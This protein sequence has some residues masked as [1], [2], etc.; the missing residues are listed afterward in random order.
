MSAVDFVIF[1]L[2]MVS[3]RWHADKQHEHRG[4]IAEHE[5]VVQ[6]NRGADP[7]Q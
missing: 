6:A 2:Y 5:R 7:A 1:G 4:G 3:I